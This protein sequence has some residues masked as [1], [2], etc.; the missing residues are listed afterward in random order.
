MSKQYY[1]P[2]GPVFLSIGGEGTANPVWMENGAWVQYAQ[3]HNAMMFM[4]EH[5]YYGH[6]HPTMYV[7]LFYYSFHP[8]FYMNSINMGDGVA[9]L[10]EHQTR[11]PKD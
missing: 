3:E 6:T 2:G 4:V 10:V 5:R 1:K 11:D 8:V 7:C 9:Q